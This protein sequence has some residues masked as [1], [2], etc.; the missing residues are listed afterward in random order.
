MYLLCF[1]P[2]LLVGTWGLVFLTDL[3]ICISFFRRG[4]K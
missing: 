1:T 4:K 2:M 3:Y